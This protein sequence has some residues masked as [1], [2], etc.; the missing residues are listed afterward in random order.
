MEWVK[1]VVTKNCALGKLCILPTQTCCGL[2]DDV[3]LDRAAARL[4]CW[5]GC[6]AHVWER[7]QRQETEESCYLCILC[8]MRPHTLTHSRTPA[9]IHSPSCSEIS[10]ACS[11][12]LHCICSIAVAKAWHRALPQ[13]PMAR[14]VRRPQSCVH[15]TFFCV[16]FFFPFPSERRVCVGRGREKYIASKKEEGREREHSP[17]H[18]H[19]LRARN[20]PCAVRDVG[21]H[22]R[23]SADQQPNT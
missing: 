17:H 3:S 16:F 15:S 8:G 14:R 18:T 7:M 21:K 19:P 11:Q 1:V 10:P 2:K 23:P 13:V 20:M 12:R 6:K 4:A 22:R 9:R 5:Q